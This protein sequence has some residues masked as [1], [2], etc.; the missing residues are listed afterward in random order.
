MTRIKQISALTASDT[1]VWL[2]IYLDLVTFGVLFSTFLY[3]RSFAPEI[4]SSSQQT[5][6]INLATLNTLL[7]LTSSLFVALAVQG[8]KN[9]GLKLT[10][11]SLT[12]AKRHFQAALFCGSSFCVIKILEYTEKIEAGISLVT[13]NFYMFY[14][15][16]TGIHSFHVVLGLSVLYLIIKTLNKTELDTQ[17]LSFIEGGGCFWHLVDLLWVI[18]FPLLYVIN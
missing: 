15:V 18:L 4:F 2:F 10:S 7:L 8:L 16:L 14:F 13:N 5:L 6:D 1:G 3:Y 11:E 17:G 12:R 9:A